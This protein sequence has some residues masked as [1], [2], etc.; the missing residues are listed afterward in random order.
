MGLFDR[1]RGEDDEVEIK[2]PRKR[3]GYSFGDESESRENEDSG[4]FVLPGM[5]PA[6][7]SSTG[8]RRRSRNRSEG[9]DR[10][11]EQNER[12]IELLEEIADS[13][14]GRDSIL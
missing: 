6:R 4:E 2:P 10:I 1:I 7:D 9:V 13:G 12:I 8:S 14:S 3:K 5:K 11:I